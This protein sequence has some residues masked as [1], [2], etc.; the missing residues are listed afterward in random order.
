MGTKVSSVLKHKGHDVVTVAP[1]QTVTWVVK[2]LTQNRIGA[3]PV[4]N[5]EGQRAAQMTIER[6]L[7]QQRNG[8]VRC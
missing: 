4:I 6:S 8:P 1:Q 7:I 3:V 5:E 2:V